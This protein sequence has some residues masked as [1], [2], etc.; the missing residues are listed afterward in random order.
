[1]RIENVRDGAVGSYN[2]SSE[3]VT[4]R[5]SLPEPDGTYQ[6]L[7]DNTPTTDYKVVNGYVVVEVPFKD[8][9]IHLA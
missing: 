7:I 5:I 8:C 6:V 2:G 9:Y 4:V 1:M 3:G